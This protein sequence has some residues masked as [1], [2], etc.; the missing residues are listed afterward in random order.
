MGGEDASLNVRGGAMMLR[1]IL[2]VFALIPR[3]AM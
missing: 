2:I 1:P 3:D